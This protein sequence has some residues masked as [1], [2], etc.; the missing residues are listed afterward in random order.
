MCDIKTTQFKHVLFFS[1][2]N[3]IY[4]VSHISLFLW[5][6]THFKRYLTLQFHSAIILKY[7]FNT[8]IW[9]T[10]LNLTI[11]D[12]LI[13]IKSL[14]KY[15]WRHQKWTLIIK[16]KE[17][18][19]FSRSFLKKSHKFTHNFKHTVQTNQNLATLYVK[20]FRNWHLYLNFRKLLTSIVL[21]NEIAP[22]RNKPE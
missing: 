1:S 7:L 13:T 9:Q 17:I 21:T 3:D 2:Q 8:I 18:I 15:F 16:K 10:I 6:K 11:I 20:T 4:F 14:K 5:S 19:F 22:G 12:I